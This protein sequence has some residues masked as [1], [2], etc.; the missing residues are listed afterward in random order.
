MIVRDESHVIRRCLDS[1]KHLIDYWIIVDTGSA[2]GTQ[3]IIQEQLRDIPGELHERPWVSFGH[4]RNE[5]MQLARKKGDYL[6]FIDADD[7]L[8]FSK[9]FILP[10][11]EEDIYS[12]L[13]RESRK[14]TYR[15]HHV[16]FLIRNDP[17]FEWAGVLHEYLKVKTPKTSRLL[18]GVHSQYTNDGA[19]SKD[20][21][22][23]LKDIEI[24]NKAIE[25]DPKNRRYVFYLARTYWSIKSGKESL[26]WFLRR[27]EMGGDPLEVYYSLLYIGIVQRYLDYSPETFIN[28]FCK[29]YLYRPTR[30]ES[31]YEVVRYF[32]ETG[33]FL[34]GHFVAGHIL[35]APLPE[36]NLF[37]ESWVYDWGTPLYYFICSLNI[38]K[39]D[40]AR[41]TLE[42]LLSN[43]RLPNNIRKFFKLDDR[44]RLLTNPSQR[45][46]AF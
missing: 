10:D 26:H 30:T 22:K 7:L 40:Q 11:L 17:E 35:S 19:R 45:T 32:A 36:D 42:T 2:D 33:N 38:G 31:L 12:I 28:S 34:L 43:P 15:E 21:N 18:T 3:K 6:L 16:H 5:A 41:S 20:P 39:L 25:E 14:D 13:Q 27:A 4:N 44:W 23:T 29:A 46:G 24:L 1:V 9:D 37:V 8:V